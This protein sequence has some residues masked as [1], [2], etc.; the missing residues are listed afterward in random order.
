MGVYVIVGHLT[1][2]TFEK[3]S[4]IEELDKK[5]ADLIE[6]LGGKLLSFYYTIGRFDFVGTVDMPSKEAL[7]K[8]LSILGKFGTVRTETLQT[9]PSETLYKIAKE[10]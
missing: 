10:I 1:H 4:N 3:L 8:F 9:I 6:S 7:V 2:S 5:S